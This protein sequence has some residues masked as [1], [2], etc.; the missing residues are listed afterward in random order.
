M[1]KTIFL[2]GL[3]GLI[4][5]GVLF[6]IRSFYDQKK[7]S[8]DQVDIETQF[9]LQKGLIA[10]NAFNGNGMRLDGITPDKSGAKA[11]LQKGDI[12]TK[13]GAYTVSHI[14][15]YMKALSTYNKGDTSTVIIKRGTEEK[16]VIITF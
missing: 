3:L 11:G 12:I 15:D 10:I 6:A 13:L 14:E 7:K 1:K 9:D 5:F 16:I 4:I 2:L 8:Q